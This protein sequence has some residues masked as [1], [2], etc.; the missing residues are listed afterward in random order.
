MKPGS[1]FQ[2]RLTAC[3]HGMETIDGVQGTERRE[4][5]TVSFLNV[6]KARSASRACYVIKSNASPLQQH[7]MLSF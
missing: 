7:P 3:M 4:N 5:K 1:Q 2:Y 6:A